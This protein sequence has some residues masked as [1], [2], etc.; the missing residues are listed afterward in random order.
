MGQLRYNDVIHSLDDRMLEFEQQTKLHWYRNR[1]TTS[2][3]YRRGIYNH[4][5]DYVYIGSKVLDEG[6]ITGFVSDVDYVSMNKQLFHELR[7]WIQF[8][9][10]YKEFSDDVFVKHMA[11]QS[12]ISDV[13]PVYKTCNYWNLS[14]EID[15]EEFAIESVRSSLLEDGLLDQNEIDRC[16][17]T[18]INRRF[19]WWGSQ[20]VYNVESCI[21]DLKSRKLSSESDGFLLAAKDLSI[22]HYPICRDFILSCP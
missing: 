8:N 22:E 20:P 14:Y 21:D 11:R 15:A 5:N 18:E 7:H 12:M 17:L 2:G 13:F 6:Q 9:K 19:S 16:L 10:L 4:D 3:C 1:M